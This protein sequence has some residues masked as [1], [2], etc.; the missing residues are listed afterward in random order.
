MSYP[1]RP[2]PAAS[3]RESDTDAGDG[4]YL[5]D[6]RSLGR[7]RVAA[8]VGLVV[9]TGSYL[10][11]LQ[12]VTDVVGGTNLFLPMALG[13]GFGAVFAARYLRP[14]L[15]V[16]VA[17]V[18]AVLGYAS[19]LSLVPNGLTILLN[20]TGELVADAVALLTGLRV[21]QIQRA[22]IWAVGF[23][24]APVFL[25]WYLALRR[26]YLGG[27]L[28]GG[29]ALFL[30]V[31]TN[32]AGPITTLV[33][34]LGGI[35]AVGL[36]ELDRREGTLLEA[37]VLVML[38]A[39]IAVVA[40][41]VSLV[42]GTPVDPLR[43]NLG[44]P[45][46]VEGQFVGSPG[47]MQVV[48]SI[49]LSPE[50]RF[51]VEADER[52]YWRTGVYDRFTGDSWVRTGQAGAYTNDSLPDPVGSTRRVV[53]RY[54]FESRTKTMPGAA[55]PVEVV[56]EAARIAQVTRQG[57]LLPSQSFIPGDSY[58]VV[59]QV[60]AATD[61]ELREAG[62]DYP[63][64]IEERY[65][66]LPASISDEFR[67]VTANVTS[68][69][70]NPYEAAELVESYLETTKNYS[71]NV[72]RPNGNIANAFLLDMEAGYC[73]YFATTMVAM[74]RAEGIPARIAVGYTPGQS[75]GDD[76]Y[77]VRGLNS[78]VWVEAYFPDHGWIRFDP[79]PAGPRERLENEVISGD[80]GDGDGGGG[81][82]SGPTLTP[83][84]TPTPTPTDSP[85]A[86]NDTA[87]TVAPEIP[88]QGPVQQ[89]DAPNETANVSSESGGGLPSIPTPS[90]QQ[91]ALGAMS[92]LGLAAGAHR[93]GLGGRV[94]RA[95]RLR[96]QPGGSP[97]D[98]VEQAVRRLELLL[99][100]E[101]R[102]RQPGETRREYVAYLESRN[103]DPRVSRVAEIHERARHAGDVDR[104]TA[105]EAVALVDEMVGERTPLL[106][107]F[108]R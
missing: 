101:Y 40:P 5:G 95:V 47:E 21:V 75:V 73:T 96:Y 71:T 33:G 18:V 27:V 64:G 37:D 102:P 26:R 58:V 83:T 28:V 52:R 36:G 62:T 10:S 67:A 65:T 82:S 68:E 74:L 72:R 29:G 88:G 94:S 87:D 57:T 41:F 50:V 42:P 31:L 25:S 22:D 38:V 89:P 63:D 4:G 70:E 17:I 105:D 60:P 104:E 19:Y 8:L 16:A 44:G 3:A 11:V 100:E 20:R 48:G 1:D 13:A 76:E 39:I 43:L 12:Y 92:L 55:Q 93:V 84:S 78:H 53:Q 2:R 79:T 46:T 99:G 103:V 77:V 24:P 15:A 59:S 23:A 90:R 7:F 66:Q 54:T 30:L 98:D 61:D 35:A 34:V 86:G 106:R 69:A 108:R 97:A 107:R 32:D 9:L 91:T 14:R 49:E 45:T 56:G 80:G 85:G 81:G 51:R 6:L